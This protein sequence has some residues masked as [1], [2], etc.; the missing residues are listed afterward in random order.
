MNKNELAHAKRI[1]R[2]VLGSSLLVLAA[3]C[4][5]AIACVL[6][7]SFVQSTALKAAFAVLLL[8]LFAG[9]LYFYNTR[10]GKRLKNI[11][12]A[13]IEK[14]TYY[15][16]ILDA[17]PFPIH[18]T[19]NDM[20]WVYMNKHFEQLL[21]EGGLITDRESAYGLPCCTASASICSTE[22]CGI[23]QLMETGKAETYFDWLD[24]K[25]KQ[26]TSAIKDTFGHS[27]GYVEV[28]T[29]L[30]SILKVN[31]YTKKEVARLSEDLDRIA[32]GDLNINL[33]VQ[34]ADRYTQEVHGDFQKINDSIASVRDSLA[35]MS[36]E[37]DKLAQAG[38]DGELDV[39]GDA[40]RLNGIYAKI[41]NGVNE[42]FESI[43]APLDVASAFISNLAKGDMQNDIENHYRGYYALLADNLNEVHHSLA[44][45]LAEAD[46][47][48]KAGRD[49]NLEVRGD[50]SSQKGFYA[51]II[52]GVNSTLDAV[53]APLKESARVLGG[54]AYN[55]YASEMSKEYHG[56]YLDLASSVNLVRSRLLSVQDALVKLGKGDLSRL[57]EFRSIGRRSE[58]DH[59]M[60]AMISAYQTIQE[61]INEADRLAE[62]AYEGDLNVRGNSSQFSGGYCGIIDGMN[63]TMEAVSAPIEEA[64]AVLQELAKGNLSVAMSGEYR[65]G[66]NRIKDGMNTAVSSFRTLLAE[67]SDAAQQVAAGSRQVAEGSQTMSQGATEQA[68]AIEELT[69]TITDI[70]VKTRQ[71]ATNATQV[72]SLASTT[73][74][75][76]QQGTQKMNEM[77]AA[78]QAI[79]ESASN[80]SKINRV[81]D[82]IAFQ[83]NILSLNASVEAAHAGQYGKSFAVVADEI[84]SLSAKSAKAAKE[85]TALIENSIDKVDDGTKIANET[86]E[87]LAKISESF[88]KVSSLV[89]TIAAAS[90]E[91]ATA[92]AQI[93]Q[94]LSQVSTVIQ[95]NSATAEESA[96]SSEELSGQAKILSESIGQ[97][98]LK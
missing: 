36:A 89:E 98:R 29:D 79:S 5:T 28:V 27:I 49:G 45:L 67:I 74:T 47:L 75:E 30:T 87:S 88:K 84:R 64:S 81:I 2:M 31:E 8:L 20:K 97:F 57:E 72:S 42:T 40:S 70:S 52:S 9:L 24:M 54:F 26:D 44:F 41:V 65:G 60:P 90:N 94:G 91:Q 1:G 15:E 17:V 71:N 12:K 51:G 6:I 21:K 73:Q 66:Y 92:V 86:A 68:S 95:T 78:M 38:L 13:F 14:N 25:C 96:A 76:A 46:K 37:A 35:A 59:I 16:T 56:A 39:R 77:L 69:S 32:N 83:T 19:D 85:T 55:D 34:E 61:L 23:R 58:N 50:E 22:A 93:D 82:D 33:N 10:I 53:V 3:T 18:V 11:I 48:A 80:I 43:K 4:V 62:A 7:F 63:R